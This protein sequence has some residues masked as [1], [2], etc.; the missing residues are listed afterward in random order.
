MKSLQVENW[1]KV[2]LRRHTILKLITAG[3]SHGKGLVAIIEGL[4]A[5]VEIKKEEIDFELKRRQY[6]FGRGERMSN[7]EKD[8]VEIIS[9][10]RHSRTI[11][12]P[13]ALYIKNRDWEKNIEIMDPYKYHSVEKIL[14]PRPGHADLAGVLKYGA[15]DIRDILERASARE[16]AARVAA[17]AVIKKFLSCFSIE[18]ISFVDSIH[19]IKANYNLNEVI[20]NTEKFREIVESSS[21]RTPDKKAEKKFIDVINE[22][23]NRGDT[24]GGTYILVAK[25]V[26]PGLGSHT[27]WD[28]RIDG[29]IAQA[30]LSIHAHKA[31]E[32]GDGFTLAEKFGSECGDEIFYSKK[33]GFFRKTNHS[34]GIEGGMTNGEPVVLRACIK[35]LSSLK[36]PLKS[37]DISK[38]KPAMASIIRS[39]ICPVASACVIGEAMLAYIIADEFLKKFGGDS[40]KET[41][42]NYKAYMKGVK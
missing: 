10:I 39:D 21:L 11:G 25:N 41:M 32:F 33:E 15:D 28:R 38:K 40:I 8:E 34:G 37:I 20:K 19:R 27:Q 31:V 5:G 35:P 3:E 18:F 2:Q 13:V 36:K 7:I 1:T 17:G 24:V 29:R 26:P 16:T 14:H 23:K 6:A 4:P 30:I 42:R 22:A 12:A 9:G